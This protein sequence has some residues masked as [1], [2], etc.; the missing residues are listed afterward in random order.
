MSALN[1]PL[2]IYKLLNKSNCRKCLLPSCLAFAAAVIQG[3]KKITDCPDLDDQ[4]IQSIIGET[5]PR[6]NFEGE[7]AD[8]LTGLKQEVE[9]ID[10]ASVAEKL[11]AVANG[12]TVAI[13]CLGRD[14]IIDSYGELNSVCHTNIWIHGPILSY[15]IHGQG[16]TICENWLPFKQLQGSADWS[17]FFSHR[18]EEDMRQLVD[19]HTELF[20]ELMDLFGAKEI[21]GGIDTDYSLLIHPLPKL[22]MVINYWLAEDDFAS[23]LSIYFD[24]TAPDNLNIEF[25]YTI[26]RGLVEMFR[27]LIVKHNMTGKLF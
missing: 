26:T 12:D 18:C 22:P 9:K 20:F 16:K 24:S 19:G 4:T 17:R 21:T 8:Q 13:N 11:G 2:E 3:Q 10:L 7:M 5:V 15:V 14:F 1:T 6:K 25:I 23:K 27:A